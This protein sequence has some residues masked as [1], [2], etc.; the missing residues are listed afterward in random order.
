MI[1]LQGQFLAILAI[2][3]RWPWA[4]TAA[5]LTMTKEPSFKALRS[6]AQVCVAAPFG[7]LPVELDCD[8]P[9]QNECLCREDLA[10]VASKYLSSCVPRQ[11]TVG[12]AEA[13]L[14]SMM[15]IYNSY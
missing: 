8:Y 4:C 5:E 9:Y 12:P 7:S 3:L 11:C 13:D 15:S 14:S 10:G 2:S 6:C 1:G